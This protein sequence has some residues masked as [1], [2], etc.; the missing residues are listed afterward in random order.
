MPGKEWVPAREGAAL[1]QQDRQLEL[2]QLR[3]RS[4]R[5]PAA[6]R[7]ELQQRWTTDSSSGGGAREATGPG[8]REVAGT[9]GGRLRAPPSDT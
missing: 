8:A 5:A 2:Q 7:G 3:G 9:E 6:A 4:P 1:R